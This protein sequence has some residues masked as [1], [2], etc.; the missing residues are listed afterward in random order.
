M[1]EF[2]KYDETYAKFFAPHLPAR[3]TVE[4]KG[5]PVQG[6]KIEIECIAFSQN[7]K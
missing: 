4:V 7:K 5:L 3:T 1:T 2:K 6:A